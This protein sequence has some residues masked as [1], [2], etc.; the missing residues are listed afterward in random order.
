MKLVA[1][2]LLGAVPPAP[3]LASVWSR[4]MA[5]QSARSSE[6]EHQPT[7]AQW[8]QWDIDLTP[9]DGLQNVTTLTIGVDGASAAGMLYIDD[10]RL[11]P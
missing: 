11:Y 7:A 3:E 8:Q 2:I 10:I 5:A 6:L 4:F 9:L 1:L